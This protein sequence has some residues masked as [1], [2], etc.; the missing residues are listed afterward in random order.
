MLS[1]ITIGAVIYLL[2][3][4]MLDENLERNTKLTTTQRNTITML[5]FVSIPY[6]LMRKAYRKAYRKARKLVC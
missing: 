3:G 4:M 1:G 6:I 5:W 2:I